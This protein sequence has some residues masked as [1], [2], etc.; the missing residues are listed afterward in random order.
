MKLYKIGFLGVGKMGGSIL[1]GIVSSSLYQ[2]DDIYLFDKNPD[3]LDYY[4]ALGYDFASDETNLFE[5]CDI[6]ILAIKPQMFNALEEVIKNKKF[7]CLIVSIAAGISIS[8]LK[9]I[10]GPLK[11]IRVMP[12]TPALIG[13]ATSVISRDDAVLDDEFNVV[14]EIFEKIGVVVELSEVQMN[15]IIPLNGSMPAYLYYFAEGFIENGIK[16]GIDEEVCKQLVANAIIGSAEMIL[17]ADKPTSVLIKDVCSP[18]GTTLAGLYVLE[19]NDFKKTID[20]A[21]DACIKRAYELANRK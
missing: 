20:T 1:N 21:A 15:E 14:K 5:C 19:D 7:N 11:C 13:K 6:V 4:K 12:N 10:F 8:A 16:N 17:K 3:V 18:G 2:K 9:N